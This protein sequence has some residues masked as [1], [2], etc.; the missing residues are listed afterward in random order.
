MGTKALTATIVTLLLAVG[1]VAGA[2]LGSNVSLEAAAASQV[3]TTAPEPVGLQVGMGQRGGGMVG[4]GYPGEDSDGVLAGVLGLTV[5]EF[6][7][8]L[9]SGQTISAI[10]AE[11]GKDIDAVIGAM[12]GRA[13]ARIEAAVAAGDMT[14]DQGDLMREGLTERMTLKVE[15]TFTGQGAGAFPR[16]MANGSQDCTHT[17]G[18]G[19]F[20]SHGVGGNGRGLRINS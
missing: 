13:T 8:A 5:D 1:F 4:L 6:H 17:P 2:L 12:V 10:A 19:G 15:R 9:Q 11:Q 14:E 16:G 3:D 18:G 7:A 20:G